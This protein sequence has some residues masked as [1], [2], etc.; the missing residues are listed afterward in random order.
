MTTTYSKVVMEFLPFF[1]LIFMD[2]KVKVMTLNE[3]GD[4]IGQ[5]KNPDYGYI[6]VTQ[7]VPTVNASGFLK[8]SERSALVK[9]LIK[10]L[11]ESKFYAGQVLPGKIVVRE[12]LEP[13]NNENPDQHAKIAGS[14][15]V[16]LCVDGQQIYRETVYTLNETENDILIQHDNGY[17][18]KEARAEQEVDKMVTANGTG[19]TSS[20][21]V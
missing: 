3:S 11:K 4:V 18:V 12:Q 8:Y 17:A 5:S 20:F 10:D 14:T 16:Q 15:G 19:I 2:N 13:F 9:G 1:N 6:R 7:R 21:T